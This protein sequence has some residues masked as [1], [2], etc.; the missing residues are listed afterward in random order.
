MVQAEY[1]RSRAVL[2]EALA[3]AER[4]QDRVALAAA[5]TY[6]GHTLVTAGDVAEGPLGCR[7]RCAAGRRWATPTALARPFSISD[8]R[9]M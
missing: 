2:N 1:A 5:S 4:C 6:L 8:M 7:R 3:M 9:L